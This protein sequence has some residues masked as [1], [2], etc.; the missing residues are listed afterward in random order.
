MIPADDPLLKEEFE[1][2]PREMLEILY[3]R[4]DGGNVSSSEFKIVVD[5]IRLLESAADRM[6]Q[7]LN[8]QVQLSTQPAIPPPP[9]PPTTSASPPLPP[10]TSPLTLGNRGRSLER[11]WER[12]G[13]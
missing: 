10:P 4:V 11:K 6:R 13:E 7:P 12:G 8:T 1:G 2:S 3:A 5:S 9:E